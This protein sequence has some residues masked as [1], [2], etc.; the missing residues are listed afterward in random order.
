MMDTIYQAIQA[1]I[2]ALV[3]RA[4][5]SRS[6]GADGTCQLEASEGDHYP[7]VEVWQQFGQASRPPQGGEAIAVCPGGA[8]EGAIVV[9]TTDRDHRPSDL[10]LGESCLYGLASGSSQAQVR[11]RPDGTVDLV[12][13]AGATA[14]L[15]GNAEPVV[16]GTTYNAAEADLL[17]ALQDTITQLQTV[18]GEWASAAV[19]STPW[20]PQ[21]G[22]QTQLATSL[23]AVQL[24]LTSFLGAASSWLSQIGRAA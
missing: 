2:S 21:Q 12:A 7:A 6:T 15:G 3:V 1:G 10:Q 16:L 4:T 23:A 22:S 20:V 11:A 24:E 9:A 14:N 8:G 5:L 19:A 13:G 18:Q 17:S